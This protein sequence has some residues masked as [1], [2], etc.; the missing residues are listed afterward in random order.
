MTVVVTD[1]SKYGIVMVGDTAV[2]NNNTAITTDDAKKIHYSKRANI[3]F[4]IWG[5]THMSG[6]ARMDKWLEYFIRDEIGN[7]E[8]IDDVCEKLEAELGANLDKLD[9]S[10]NELRRGVHVA[11]YKNGL[12]VIYHLHTGPEVGEQERITFHKDY[13]DVHV[14]VMIAEIAKSLPQVK[15]DVWRVY[16]EFLEQEVPIHLRNGYIP[17]FAKVF[18]RI[19]DYSLD[20]KNT[21]EINFPYSSLGERVEFFE[22]LVLIVAET[23]RLSRLPQRVNSRLD[24]IGFTSDGLRIDRRT[25]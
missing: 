12:P 24:A 14:P 1:A 13:P 19:R 10:W 6:N 20:I 7:G 9:C 15:F 5:T 21:L 22:L 18:D 4:A 17:H 2:S 16:G 25:R 23:L 11:G 3:G 8:P